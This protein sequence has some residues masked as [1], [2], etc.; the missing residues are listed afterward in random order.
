VNRI[1]DFQGSA[2][3]APER[4]RSDSKY[5]LKEWAC[6]QVAPVGKPS[7]LEDLKLIRIT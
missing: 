3:A 1:R 4:P 6:Q 7:F 2:A 5:I